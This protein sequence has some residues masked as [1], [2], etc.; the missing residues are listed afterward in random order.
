MITQKPWEMPEWM[1][2]YRELIMTNGESVENLVNDES[3]WQV[4]AMRAIIAAG[5]KCQV[6]LL[7][8]LHA[9]KQLD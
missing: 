7:Y 9:A 3:P 2:R 4:N 6:G 5:V 1:E 8:R